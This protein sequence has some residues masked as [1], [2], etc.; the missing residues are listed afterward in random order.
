M[1]LDWSQNIAAKTT[2]SP[3]SLRGRTTPY[4]AAPRTWD[5]VAEGADDPL[6]IEQLRY[7]EVLDRVAAH[8]DLFGDLL[9]G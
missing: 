5:E 2:I 6:G 7:D 4:V 1:F 3:Y 8:G 9:A